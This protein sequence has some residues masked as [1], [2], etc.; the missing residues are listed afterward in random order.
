MQIILM[1]YPSK[2]STTLRLTFKT[3]LSMSLGFCD[4]DRKA[5]LSKAYSWKVCKCPEFPGFRIPNCQCKPPD[6]SPLLQIRWKRLVIDE[7]HVSSSLSTRLTPF[8]KLL[9]V[10]ARWI[11]SGTPTTNLLGLSFGGSGTE[12]EG[13]MTSTPSQDE[14]QSQSDDDD[15]SLFG[16]NEHR[17]S[18]SSAP[19]PSTRI[20]SS[21]DSQDIQKLMN[22]VS[23]FIGVKFLADHQVIRTHLKDALLSDEG[24][25]PGAINML[26]QLM[27]TVMI[28]HRYVNFI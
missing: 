10:Q 4:E 19:I 23:Q 14:L 17:E 13:V 3:E 12:E 18:P 2:L 22:M 16:D 5:N 8:T 9:S 20:W 11:V 21:S 26:V 24:P 1:S 27:K 6:I 25:R 28:R 7:G 15:D